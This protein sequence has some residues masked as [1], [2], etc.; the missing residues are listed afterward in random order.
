MLM[1]NVSQ[2][3]LTFYGVL[4]KPICSDLNVEVLEDSL[5]VFNLLCND[6]DGDSLHYHIV[7]APSDGIVELTESEARYIP[8]TDY[9]GLDNFE[10]S[11][12]DGFVESDY[13][14]VN[15]TVIPGNNAPARKDFWSKA[16]TPQNLMRVSF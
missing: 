4:D 8:N 14:T 10:Y 15:I 11:A 7:S 9:H 12:D 16:C 6:I 5:V 2:S 1:E 3:N 13:S